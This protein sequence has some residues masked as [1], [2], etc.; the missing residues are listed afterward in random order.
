MF[1]IVPKTILVSTKKLFAVII[2]IMLL[3]SYQALASYFSWISVLPFSITALCLCFLSW[4]LPQ[5]NIFIYVFTFY[6]HFMRA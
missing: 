5:Y 4:H 2:I 1:G 6:L 3:M